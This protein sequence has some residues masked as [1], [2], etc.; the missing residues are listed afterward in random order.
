[1]RAVRAFSNRRDPSGPVT[2]RRS[3]LALHGWQYVIGSC[4]LS[5]SQANSIN[6]GIQ[7]L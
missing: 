1:M 5:G 6:S 3:N 4:D 2:T 7:T